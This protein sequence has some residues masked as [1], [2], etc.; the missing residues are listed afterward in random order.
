MKFSQFLQSAVITFCFTVAVCLGATVLA[1]AQERISADDIVSK[2]LEA[3]GGASQRDPSRSRTI[4]GNSIMTLKTGGSGQASGP[5]A[6]MS[7]IEAVF[8]DA[9]FAS[10]DYPFEQ[11]MFDGRKLGVKQFRPGARSPLGEF[12]LAY[13]EVFKEGLVGGTLSSNWAML[14]VAK[15]RPKLKVEK[16]AQIDGRD[17]Y[18]VRFDPRRNSD[19]QISLYFDAETFR[20]IRT[21]YERSVAAQSARIGATNTQSSAQQET[22][23]RVVESFSDFVSAAGMSLPKTYTVEYSIFSRSPILIEWAFNWSEFSFNETL[24]FQSLFSDKKP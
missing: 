10:P 21:E 16:T 8:L 13:D 7:H 14:H 15:R 4:R 20:H 23:F 19:L 1:G 3:L 6:M 5:A 17:A 22:R 9:K 11:I 18:K 2:H 24:D 12:F